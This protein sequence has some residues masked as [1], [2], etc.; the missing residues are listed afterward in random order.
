M[1]IE[2][3]DLIFEIRKY[4]DAI[5]NDDGSIKLVRN[6]RP[7]INEFL[8]AEETIMGIS[9]II[10]DFDTVYQNM[11]HSYQKYTEL[12]QYERTSYVLAV[13]YT[14]EMR[15]EGKIPIHNKIEFNDLINQ[16]WKNF[17]E[18]LIQNNLSHRLINEISYQGILDQSAIDYEYKKRK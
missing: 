14:M 15:D 2:L 9:Y 3:F 7:I 5:Y 18:Y 10:S 8:N 1:D 12:N 13:T 17:K 16:R 6:I 4:E 11:I